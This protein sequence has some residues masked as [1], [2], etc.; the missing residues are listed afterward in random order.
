[1][2]AHPTGRPATRTR[3]VVL[4]AR[5]KPPRKSSVT[6]AKSRRWRR[7]ERPPGAQ[8]SHEP[9]RWE[10]Q[11]PRSAAVSRSY[12]R[13]RAQRCAGRVKHSPRPAHSPRQL[14]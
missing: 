7:A 14:R 11:P 6:G 3:W 1:M 12:R 9:L 2:P 10:P 8:G 4:L 13:E 5:L